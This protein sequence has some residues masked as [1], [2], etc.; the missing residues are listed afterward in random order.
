MQSVLIQV[1]EADPLVDP[2][3]L[4]GD[5]SRHLGVP[6]HITLAG[7]YPL[8]AE[9]PK[10]VPARIAQRAKSI[11]FTLSGVGRV[12]DSTCLLVADEKPLAALRGEYLDA[13]GGEE[14]TDRTWKFHLT[15]SR[16]ASAAAESLI[17]EALEPSLP[18]ECEVGELSLATLRGEE[19]TLVP[20]RG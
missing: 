18:L 3:R 20:V 1:P 17:R 15:I 14:Q 7:P 6:A 11:R 12:G 4:E 13:I 9:L 16:G 8:S 2:F 5:W 10:Q 19:L